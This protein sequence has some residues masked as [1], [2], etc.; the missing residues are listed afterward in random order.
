MSRDGNPKRKKFRMSISDRQLSKW[1]VSLILPLFSFTGLGGSRLNRLARV[2]VLACAGKCTINQAVKKV[3]KCLTAGALR[4]HL[5]KE[6]N[7]KPI[8]KRIN[9]I[10][11]K[12]AMKILSGK[13]LEFAVDLVYLPYHGQHM[14]EENEIVRSKAKHGTTHFHAYATLYVIVLGKRFTLAVR[15]VK[16]NTSKIEILEFF[17]KTIRDLDIH[18]RT[19][20]IDR[21]FCSVEVINY[22]KRRHI[23]AVIA[24]PQKGKKNG[25]KSLLRGKKS[26]IVRYTMTSGQG[27]TARS[28]EFDMMIVCKYAK[29]KYGRKGVA[30]FTYALINITI[31]PGECYQKYRKRFG[32]ESS[33]RMMNSARARTSS[34]SP[35][36]RL[37]YIGVSLILQNA[38]VY[39]N[40]TYMRE[41]RQGVRKPKEGLTL[42]SFL[43]LIIQGLKAIMGKITAIIPLNYPTRKINLF[44]SLLPYTGGGNV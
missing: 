43:E 37:I 30:Y 29:N 5:R 9:A 10:L 24:V 21:G 39:L 41:R 4:H 35:E 14:K 19:L 40:W 23:R 7:I 34:R 13:W 31:K 22:L 8:E 1:V 15:Y 17:R 12:I 26:R 2:V 42:N 28:I 16:K 38:W 11:Q 20:Y 6:V 27:R 18:I 32:I 36:L 33:Y 25:V 44:S 3:K